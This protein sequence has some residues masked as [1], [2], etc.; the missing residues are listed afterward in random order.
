M[1]QFWPR[2]KKSSRTRGFLFALP[3][4]D[5][6]VLQGARRIF[7]GSRTPQFYFE[8]EKKNNNWGVNGTLWKCCFR[9]RTNTRRRRIWEEENFKT[10]MNNTVTCSP[11]RRFWCPKKS[12]GIGEQAI[13]LLFTFNIHF[14]GRELGEQAGEKDHTRREGP[15]S[16][17]FEIGTNGYLLPQWRG[18]FVFLKQSRL[19]EQAIV[20]L[21]TYIGFFTE[22]PKI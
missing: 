10:W 17:F 13:V 7:T 18:S 21:F 20:F 19:R 16:S 6:W 22:R 14:R 11:T 5:A 4:I 1:L 12:R 3:H 9:L 2:P 15:V 8:I